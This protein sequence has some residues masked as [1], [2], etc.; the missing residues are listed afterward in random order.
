[1]PGKDSNKS[2]QKPPNRKTTPTGDKK[3]REP[4]NKMPSVKKPRIIESIKLHFVQQYFRQSDMV[5]MDNPEGAEAEVPQYASLNEI[6]GAEDKPE[7]EQEPK[8]EE[9]EEIPKEEEGEPEEVEPEE[10]EE[11]VASDDGDK[12]MEKE[13]QPYDP[14]DVMEIEVKVSTKVKALKKLIL[15]KIELYKKANVIMLKKQEQGITKQIDSAS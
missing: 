11:Y 10:H 4:G 8:E 7:E 14:N 1:M 6:D 9:E 13:F 3:Q 2:K 5:K 12:E 15:E